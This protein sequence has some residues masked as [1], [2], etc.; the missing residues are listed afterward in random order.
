MK[1]PPDHFKALG[2]E[3]DASPDAIR[4][5]FFELA[6]Q[7]HPDANPDPA[8]RER[9]LRIREAYEVLS[10]S[11]KRAEYEA[12]LP[13]LPAAPEIA[14]S[15]VYSRPV[16][17]A[18]QEPQLAYVL[19]ELASASAPE[20]LRQPPVHVCLV[21]DRS[22]SMKGERMELVKA[23]IL[24]FL[25]LLKP[26]DLVSVVAFSDRAEVVIP[27]SRMD[28]LARFESRINAITTGGGTEMRSGLEAGAAQFSYGRGVQMLRQMILLTD[29]HTYGDDEA[30]LEVAQKVAAEGVVINAFGLGH[31]WNDAFLDRLTGL[32]G[33]NVLFIT[34]PRDLYQFLEQKMQTLA[35]LYARQIQFDFQSDRD[36]ELRYAFRIQPE[37]GPL[38]IANPLMLGDLSYG[39]K[40][41]F[42][43]EFL[44]PS[45]AP[46]TQGVTLA[47]GRLVMELSAGNQRESRLP[48]RL[49]RGV[50]VEPALEPPPMVLVEAM[51]H[52]SLYRLQD[53]ARKEVATGNI[54]KATRHLQYLATHL[55][56]QGKRDLAHAVLVEAEHIQKNQQFSLE[57]DKRIKFG[58]RALLLP[59]GVES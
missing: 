14:I 40:M 48:L 15:T 41:V 45:L 2:V 53:K 46:E 19:L 10:N 33:G 16:I 3:R 35:S 38:E 36:V 26:Q 47:H 24:P 1:E 13:P 42:L 50:E 32:S 7:Y 23:N 25:K 17:P 20:K 37:I 52:L 4:T 51:S 39:K 18:L 58:T 11:K 30:C 22:T 6:R 28:N 43:F 5:A 31:E 21:I 9:F 29:G 49:K 59:S 44:L 55:L 54:A 56:S 34:S 57:G 27:P 12:T 8:M